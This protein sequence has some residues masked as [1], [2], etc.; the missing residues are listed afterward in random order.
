MIE[1]PRTTLQ[2]VAGAHRAEF[3][4]IGTHEPTYLGFPEPA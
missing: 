2:A 3:I 1:L 4:S